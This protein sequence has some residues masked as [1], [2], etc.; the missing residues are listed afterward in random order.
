MNNY[1]LKGQETDRLF[2]R[3]LQR[4]DFKAW[5]GFHQ[6][7]RTSRFW[8][9][10]PDAPQVACEQD[11]ARTFYRYQNNLGGKQAVILKGSSKLIGLCG[12]L[13]QKVEGVQEIEIAYSLL[14][15]YWGKGY[16]SEAAEM[17]S[18]YGFEHLGVTS[19]ISIIQVDN[20]PS[21]KVALRLGMFSDKMTTYGGNEV[22]IYRIN[23]TI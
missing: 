18:K 13:V 23:R 5:L 4:K 9:G 22:Y 21:Q 15:D 2:F 7:R 1:L 14:P 3:K 8:N 20:V 16:A 17:C 6:D 10:L 12:L 19:L 11:F